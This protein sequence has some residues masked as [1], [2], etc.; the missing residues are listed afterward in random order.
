MSFRLGYLTQRERDI[1][2]LRRRRNT[3]SQIG[4][5]MG[6]SRQAI[7]KA[8][9]IMDQKVKQAF[10]EVADASHLEPRSI[11]LVEGIMEAHSPAHKVPVV[12]SFSKA[13]GVKVWYL[14]EG[15]CGGCHLES[16]CRETLESE[17]RERG[18]EITAIDNLRPPTR[19]A[20]KIF[21]FHDAG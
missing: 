14:H 2:D 19:L 9:Q 10:L 4:R 21:G 1:W 20:T 8:Y 3:Q 15:N 18:I 13:N 16:S 6:V 12:V 7:H 17:A 11:D 5:T